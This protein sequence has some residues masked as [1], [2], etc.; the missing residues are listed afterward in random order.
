MPPPTH[1]LRSQNRAGFSLVEVAL[2]LAIIAFGLVALMGLLP[3]GLAQFR[4]AMDT[5]IGAQIFQRVMGD[6]QQTDFDTLLASAT[7]RADG[8]YALP[9]RYFDDQ[10]NEVKAQ[11]T[12]GITAA[13]AERILYHVRVR[14]SEPGAADV[15]RHRNENLTSL[16]SERGK[17]FNPRDSTFVTVQVAKNPGSRA[18]PLDERWLWDA[19]AAVRIGVPLRSY[20]AIVTRNGYPRHSTPTP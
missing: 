18:I 17:R 15:S 14:G 13:D 20:P 1:R 5:T 9:I 4:D 11:G 3:V 8:H 16:P 2:A 19:R 10:G 12:D 6:V 7:E